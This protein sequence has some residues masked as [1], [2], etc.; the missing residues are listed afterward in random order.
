MAQQGN[1]NT[2]KADPTGLKRG[3]YL[4]TVVLALCVWIFSVPTEFRRNRFCSAE[5][6]ELYPN[7]KCMTAT[8][9]VSGLSQYYANGGGVHFDFSIEEEE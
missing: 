9:W 2:N 7:R 6:V 5:Q 3:A 4:M 1:D 8:Q